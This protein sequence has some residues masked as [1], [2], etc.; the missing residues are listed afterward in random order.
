M[1]RFWLKMDFMHRCTEVKKTCKSAVYS[2]L[3]DAEQKRN[4]KIKLSVDIPVA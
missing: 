4:K 1:S 3:L 2:A